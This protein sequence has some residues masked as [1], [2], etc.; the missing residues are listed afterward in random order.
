MQPSQYVAPSKPFSVECYRSTPTWKCS[1][2]ANEQVLLEAW[3]SEALFVQLCS[4]DS[5]FKRLPSTD[6]ADSAVQAEVASFR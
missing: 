3:V 4:Q 1:L 6:N 5:K 2:Q